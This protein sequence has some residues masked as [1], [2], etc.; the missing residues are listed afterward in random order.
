M[1]LDGIHKIEFWKFDFF[2]N[3]PTNVDQKLPKSCCWPIRVRY[4]THFVTLSIILKIVYFSPTFLPFTT[5]FKLNNAICWPRSQHMLT[6]ISTLTKHHIKPIFRHVWSLKCIACLWN[7]SGSAK[8]VFF[9]W[10]WQIFTFS[11]TK[12]RR[13]VAQ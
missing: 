8:N 5:Y 3:K 12:T 9:D 13:F 10:F 7:S 1:K 2:C 6:K 4:A 11:H